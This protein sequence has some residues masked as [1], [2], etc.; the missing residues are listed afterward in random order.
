MKL[1]FEDIIKIVES[2][3]TLI[4]KSI[5]EG[6]VIKRL[7]DDNTFDEV[8][9]ILSK[10][11]VKSTDITVSEEGTLINSNHYNAQKLKMLLAPFHTLE[12]MEVKDA[13]NLLLKN[14]FFTEIKDPMTGEIQ[15]DSADASASADSLGEVPTGTPSTPSSG[16]SE[17]AVPQNI[18]DLA[19]T[20]DGLLNNIE[21][22]IVSDTELELEMSDDIVSIIKNNEKM[23]DG[24]EVTILPDLITITKK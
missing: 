6:L 19:K 9:L 23:F 5:D 8:M 2:D 24:F 16:D 22:T 15:E 11:G 3:K 13:W 10:F 14:V 21:I 7:Q 1:N 12:E 18:S 17:S 20:L 4:V